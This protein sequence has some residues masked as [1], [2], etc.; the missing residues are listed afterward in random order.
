MILDHTFVICAYKKSE[1][2][3]QC[4]KSILNQSVLDKVIMVTSTPNGHIKNMSDK[5]NIPL[6]INQKPSSIY[7]DWNFGISQVQTNFFTIAH[8][9]DIYHK[10]YLEDVIRKFQE[11][12]H[13]L[14]YF[15]DYSEIRLNKEVTDTR[16]LNIKRKLLFPLRL[17]RF[18]GNKWI[19]RRILS[20]GNP[21]CCP[22]VSYCK[23]N[24]KN[25]AFSDHFSCDLDWYAWEN[26]SKKRG[27]FIYSPNILM[28]HRIH[29][30][31][32]T[33]ELIEN[34]VRYNEDYKMF[35]LFWPKFI[36]NILIKFYSKSLK[37]N[38]SN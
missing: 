2:L 22:A 12:K 8:Q 18:R 1:Y 33:T 3:E 21:I 34:N 16:L 14:I 17:K 29:E 20:L 10:D 5:Y 38:S 4:I 28:S 13:P 25:F 35:R 32:T 31:S 23:D 9:D 36:S 30:Q 37:S 7:G 24:L 26:I 19:R 15:C 11:S 27:D 6:F